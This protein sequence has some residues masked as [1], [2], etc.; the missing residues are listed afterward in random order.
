MVD[1]FCHFQVL[2]N[3]HHTDSGTHR[4]FWSKSDLNLIC[5]NPKI[6]NVSK[7]K[8]T[9]VD[10]ILILLTVWYYILNLTKTSPILHTKCPALK[11]ITEYYISALGHNG[12][13]PAVSLSLSFYSSFS[14]EQKNTFPEPL[15]QSFIHTIDHLKHVNMSIP[16][17]H[18]SSR[19]KEN[20][21]KQTRSVWR[22]H[23]DH[24]VL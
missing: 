23:L 18:L 9:Q 8:G 3:Q 1:H 2:G 12:I 5:T 4:K 16:S 14:H 6:P 13:K 17:L 19:K 24:C 11:S 22:D 20:N 7:K 15:S 10:L 21:S